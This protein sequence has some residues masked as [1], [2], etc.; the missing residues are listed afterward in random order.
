MKVTVDVTQELINKHGDRAEKPCDCPIFHALRA[1]GIPVSL[2]W[3]E[4]FGVVGDD[5]YGFEPEIQQWQ[6]RAM[7]EGKQAVAPISFEVEV[8][9]Y[10]A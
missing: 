3:V 5:W 9:H 2:V 4:E 7:E 6:E 10:D 1:A 8:G